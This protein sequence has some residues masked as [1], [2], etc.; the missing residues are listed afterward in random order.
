MNEQTQREAACGPP[1]PSLPN[2]ICCSSPEH[3]MAHGHHLRIPF[4]KPV[5]CRLASPRL[6]PGHQP[7]R[8]A[9]ERHSVPGLLPCLGRSHL[10]PASLTRPGNQAGGCVLEVTVVL[11]WVRIRILRSGNGAL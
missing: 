6:E 11:A 5:R 10:A 7:E 3:V 8:E 4:N 1:P 9:G 2:V